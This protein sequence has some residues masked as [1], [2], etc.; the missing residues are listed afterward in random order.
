MEKEHILKE[1]KRTAR[2]NGDTALGARKFFSLTGIRESDWRGKYWARWRDALIEAG[3]SP[4]QYNVAY[5]EE[6]LISKLATL[7][8]EIGRYPVQAELR[9][10]SRKDADLPS[11]NAFRRLGSKSEIATKI[12]DFCRKQT[13][14]DD[15]IQICSSSCID[16]DKTSTIKDDSY[17]E[18]EF[19]YVYL[20][21]SGHYYK[22]DR[23]NAVGRRK[24]EEWRVV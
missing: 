12:I 3:F 23:S 13:G 5:G 7:I 21:Q 4:N 10:Q 20:M 22:I 2:E 9:M 15:V 24:A 17:D 19:G 14:Y 16:S 11:Q 8:K 18:K 1:I 6:Y